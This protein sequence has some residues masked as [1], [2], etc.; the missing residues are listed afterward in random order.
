MTTDIHPAKIISKYYSSNPV[1]WKILLDHSRKVTQRALKI[2]HSLYS[3]GEPIDLKFVA[4]AAMLH[5][6]GMILTDTPELDCHGA[7]SYLQHGIRGKE[8]LEQEGLFKHARVCER[9]IGVGLTATEILQQQLPLP[10][11]DMQ[12][13]T[14]EEQII[15]YADLFYSK[16][17]KNREDE[18]T[19]EEVRDKLKKYGRKKV[20]IFDQWLEKF[21]PELI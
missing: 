10:A 3:Q 15:S 21:E 18:K 12:P 19:P 1:A 17:L 4:E 5:D 16:N 14:L 6:I 7:G 8:I 13:E 20:A 11:R 2:A 9:H